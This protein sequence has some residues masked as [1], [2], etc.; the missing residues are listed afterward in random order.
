MEA[1]KQGDAREMLGAAEMLSR[2]SNKDAIDK[3]RQAY[4]AALN[5][6]D[7]VTR[8]KALI[9]MGRCAFML[10]RTA[11]AI[12]WLLECIS[13][14]EK[15]NLPEQMAEAYNQ[16]GNTYQV[17]SDFG[18]S[19]SCYLD[20]LDIIR[21]NGLA[22]LEGSILNNIG[23]LYMTLEDYDRAAEYFLLSYEKDK[24]TSTTSAVLL[25]N[26]ASIYSKKR[27]FD[28]ADRYMNAA[29]EALKDENDL[30]MN[31]WSL[32]TQ[33]EISQSK[34][35]MTDAIDYYRKAIS[36]CRET[37]DVFNE[38]DMGAKIGHLL[39]EAGNYDDALKVLISTH[40]MSG[41]LKSYEV[42]R[43]IPLLI[44]KCYTAV[45]QD[46]ASLEYYKLHSQYVEQSE[47]EHMANQRN[48]V[49]LQ[50]QQH[51]TD[52]ERIRLKQLSEELLRTTDELKEA[53][54]TMERQ[55]IMDPLTGIRNRR[56]MDSMLD[57]SWKICQES[58]RPFTLMLVDLDCFK[59]FNDHYGHPAG[60]DDLKRV[61][62]SL[63][64]TLGDE[65]LV[66]RFG[67]DEFIA[68]LPGVSGDEARALGNR[69][70][71]NVKALHIPH[72]RNE[73]SSLQTITI[74][75]ISLVPGKDDV[76]SSV[77]HMADN[78][79]YEGKKQGKDR[80]VLYTRE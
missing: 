64:E 30:L 43:K 71:D 62:K 9:L 33:G 73:A 65:K 47:N 76:Q 68:V 10:G 56:S 74:G 70:I 44:A 18:R 55:A 42:R 21:D 57:S 17:M 67:G 19:I 53:Y 27:L 49:F 26:L 52:L 77:L 12:K 58:S 72:E 29:T 61:A 11:D 6:N 4:V 80:L 34:G 59:N 7:N 13:T 8:L 78:A 41:E 46:K 14:A 38:C 31:A 35:S 28:S 25:F 75:A 40:D 79:L 3:A 48:S 5:S 32:L 15:L 51:E 37:G 23:A 69:L 24:S 66:G 63:Q 22:S 50:V 2:T 45:K 60:D 36:L 1:L 54:A 39:M 16:L 20:A